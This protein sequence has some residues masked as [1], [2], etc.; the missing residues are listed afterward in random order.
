[1]KSAATEK[2]SKVAKKIHRPQKPEFGGSLGSHLTNVQMLNIIHAL[3]TLGK[4]IPTQ[5]IDGV[6][7]E[8]ERPKEIDKDKEMAEYYR[9]QSE[10]RN[11]RKR[12]FMWLRKIG[13]GEF[14]S[15]RCSKAI[16]KIME[17]RGI[18]LTQLHERLLY[19]QKIALPTL[20]KFINSGLLCVQVET[21]LEI[22]RMIDANPYDLAQYFI[23][24]KV[25]VA[26]KSLNVVAAERVDKW[27]RENGW[28]YYKDGAKKPYQPAK[29]LFK[30][31]KK[32]SYHAKFRKTLPPTNGCSTPGSDPKS[33]GSDSSGRRDPRTG[34]Y[35]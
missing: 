35:T 13:S 12:K 27:F 24:D 34:R 25:N 6:T 17:V 21:V 32:G 5:K 1:M 8:I 3:P 14:C 15:D 20:S 10:A 26:K 29:P 31:K 4:V 2:Q 19:R 30:K 9:A 11:L 22:A 23:V 18:T 16:K 28:M 7:V 33:A